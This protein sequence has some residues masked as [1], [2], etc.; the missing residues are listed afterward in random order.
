MRTETAQKYH[1][2]WREAPTFV[3]NSILEVRIKFYANILSVVA[4]TIRSL[5]FFQ[6]INFVIYFIPRLVFV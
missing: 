5:T 3:Q 2:W 1:R 4:I 6:I